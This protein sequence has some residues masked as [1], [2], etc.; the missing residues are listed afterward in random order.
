MNNAL[1][2]TSFFERV[3]NIEQSEKMKSEP[4]HSSVIRLSTDTPPLP[5]A[6]KPKSGKGKET[7]TTLL[8]VISTEPKSKGLRQQSAE[9]EETPAT[10]ADSVPG[11]DQPETPTETL[12]ETQT[13]TLAKNPVLDRA[14]SEL[15]EDEVRVPGP[16]IRSFAS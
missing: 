12:E 8:G 11:G 7:Q 1:K 4:N 5:I 15:G 10:R 2:S 3:D 14:E 13:D 9:V 16:V 6:G